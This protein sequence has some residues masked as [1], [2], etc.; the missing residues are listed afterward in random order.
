MKKC[1]A[2]FITGVLLSI[3]IFA[4]ANSFTALPATFNIYVEGEEFKSEN[5][6]LVIEG[7]TYLPLR[8]IGE[9]LGINVDWNEELR[10]VEINKN[11]NTITQ[12]KTDGVYKVVKVIDGDTFVINFNGQEEN[13][14]LIGVDTPETV[15]PTKDEEPY[16]K[17]AS[18]FTKL[19]IEGKE[20]TLEFDVQ[21]RDTYGRLLAY[22]YVN[23][24]MLNKTLLKKGYAIVS[25]FP[26]NV[27]Y[28]DDF[29]QL[30]QQAIE[31]KIGL[32]KDEYY[33]NQIIPAKININTA[34]E[35]ELKHIIHI[36]DDRAKQII[37]LRPFKSL[38]DLVRVNGIG[39]IRVQDI[40]NEGKAFIE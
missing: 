21:E 24:E 12:N 25:T 22:V 5:P 34:S 15:H 27:K 37:K 32:W 9:A 30:Q 11:N 36:D 13:V 26:P 17:E 20:V 7:R 33:Q 31:N 29:T 2:T 3:T 40:I 19:Q 39:N 10:R 18:D 4:V 16:G 6:P 14:R 28:V 1:I 38:E 35:E 23:G 8:A